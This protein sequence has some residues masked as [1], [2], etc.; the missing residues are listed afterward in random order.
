MLTS[1]G[2]RPLDKDAVDALLVTYA[3]EG[4]RLIAVAAGPLTLAEGAVFSAEHL[5]G[6][7]LLGLVGMIDPLRPEAAPAIEQCRAAG[8]EVSMITGDHP[9]TA[10]TIAREL[11]MA[12]DPAQVVDGGALNEAQ[13]V[14][15]DVVDALT[16]QARVFA[17]V[18]PEQK[19][20]IVESLTRNGHFVAVTGDGANDAPALRA[21][22]IG[23]AIGRIGTDVAR[24]S[25]D[26]II[27]DDNISSV[28]AG[29][30]EGRTAYANVRKVIFLLISTGAAEIVLFLLA[31]LFE[32][33]LPLL[34]A[35]LLWLN[36][37]TNGI[38]DV[39]LAFEPA[40][41]DELRKPPR[42]PREPIFNR[43]MIERT[44]ISA[45]TIGVMAFALFYVLLETGYTVDE[46]RNGTLLLMVLFENVH[47]FNSRSETLSAF[48]HNPLRNKILLFGTAAAQ[49]IHIGAMHA[50]VISDVLR[51]QPVSPHNW[52]ILLSLA[53][54]ILIV[55][56]LHKWAWNRR[57]PAPS[58]ST[59]RA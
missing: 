22:H 18:A 27:T 13:R 46:A 58:G 25:S 35:Q 32:L 14:G 33:P 5:K 55:M 21:A 24:E 10:Y 54:T 37:V 6:L 38:Q 47:V 15:E 4:Y 29:I 23:V 1:E 57:F 43:L 28:V 12:D 56:E 30:E 39:A 31:L 19:L 8:I 36:L 59:R 11:G 9:A 53:V 41:G 16:R 48:R 52:A 45:L 34:A 2:V 44:V 7:T 51:V 20:A 50:P 49:L 26:M 40:E 42:P 17:R 3:G